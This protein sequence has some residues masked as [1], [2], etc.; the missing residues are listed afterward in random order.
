GRYPR[1][2]QDNQLGKTGTILRQ[3]RPPGGNRLRRHL[4]TRC[5][6]STAATSYQGRDSRLRGTGKE[7]AG[8]HCEAW[9]RALQEGKFRSSNYGHGR[10]PP[11]R[12][13]PNGRD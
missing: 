4:Q 3:E 9:P 1:N 11:E 5:V 7:E 12:E 8:R 6:R 2:W 10:T 13:G